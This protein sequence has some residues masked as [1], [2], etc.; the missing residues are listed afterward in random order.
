ME[1]HAHRATGPSRFGGPLAVVE[2]RM[3]DRIAEVP[4]DPGQD[5]MPRAH[6]IAAAPDLLAALEVV[7]YAAR[8]GPVL[9]RDAAHKQARAAITKANGGA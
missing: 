7:L 1:W 8:D 3:G 4:A 2:G 6:L 9:K 5:P